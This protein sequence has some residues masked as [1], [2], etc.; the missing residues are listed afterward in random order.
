MKTFI[1]TS[2]S[3]PQELSLGDLSSAIFE[4]AVDA[5]IVIDNTGII[6]ALNP[7]AEEIFGFARTELIGSNVSILMPDPDS[8]KHDDY[9]RAYTKTG[10]KKI[11]GKGREVVGK[12]KEGSLFP[13]HLSI[14]EL[15]VG[16][17]QLYVGIC[18]DITARKQMIEQI[19]YMATHDSLTGCVNRNNLHEKLQDLMLSC[20]NGEWQLVMLFIDLDGFKQINDHYDHDVGDRLLSNLAQRLQENLTKSDL[21][22]RMGGD[23]FLVASIQSRERNAPRRLGQRLLDSLSKPFDI[24]GIEIRVRASIGI[25][26]H[27][28]HSQ[29]SDQLVNDADIAMYQAKAEGG[30]CIRFFRLDLRDKME[31]TFRTVG[32]LRK[33][34][35]LNQFELHYQ[36]Q[37][38]LA[39]P[40]RPS[41]LEALIRWHDGSYGTISPANFIPLAEEYGLMPA[42]SRLVL[43]RACSDNKE[44]IAEGLLDVPVAVNICSNSFLQS[45]FI[46]QV[47]ATLRRVGLPASRLEIEITESIAIHD[48]SLAVKTILALHDIGVE[49]SMDDFGTG[50]SSPGTLKR[51]PIDRLKI[52]RAF[53][54]ELPQNEFD[55]AIVQA[56]LILAKSIGMQVVAEGIENEEQLCFLQQNGCSYGQGYW[57]ARPLPLSKL[58]NLLASKEEIHG[59]NLLFKN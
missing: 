57:Y 3:K 39:P 21:L 30:N 20:E 43:E 35:E 8:S 33:A 24:K 25:S 55:R 52:D 40:Y 15:S 47:S 6:H 23:E 45:D 29:N 32:R 5:M 27:P 9:L 28:G 13:M 2:E 19:T 18:H 46:G 14:G 31:S 53:I 56:T 22:A 16:E 51:L 12:R 17:Q 11:I 26:L 4:A 59:K 36:L 34:I 10:E 49:V 41:G 7:A 58:K 37:F 42:I 54:S 48:I 50:Y 38:E 1:T 44:L